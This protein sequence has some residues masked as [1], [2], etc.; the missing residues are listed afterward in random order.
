[1]VNEGTATAQACQF[2]ISIGRGRYL[3]Q[4]GVFYNFRGE[5]VYMVISHKFA[6]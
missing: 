5:L 6:H 4:R 1:M 3:A 2:M